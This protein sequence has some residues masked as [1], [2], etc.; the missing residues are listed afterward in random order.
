MTEKTTE[1]ITTE[2]KEEKRTDENVIF[3][4]FYYFLPY[5]FI[6][7]TSLKILDLDSYI[8]SVEFHIFDNKSLQNGENIF[9]Q[10]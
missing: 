10:L 1:K 4:V 6:L 2:V 5:F 8:E 7:P 3:V 9:F